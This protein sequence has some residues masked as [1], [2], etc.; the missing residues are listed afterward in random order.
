MEYITVL[1]SWSGDV[2]NFINM[3]MNYL[4]DI[5]H[6]S[7]LNLYFVV[8]VDFDFGCMNEAEVSNEILTIYIYDHQLGTHKFFVIRN[9]EMV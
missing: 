1:L 7:L 2:C 5:H 6:G 4:S 8:Q 3:I 9:L